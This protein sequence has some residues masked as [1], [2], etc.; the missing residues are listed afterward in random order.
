MLGLAGIKAAMV[1]TEESEL[2]KAMK[3]L[4]VDGDRG[5]H[6]DNKAPHTIYNAVKTEHKTKVKWARKDAKTVRTAK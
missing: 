2:E 3:A 4:I 1:S 5:A 6:F